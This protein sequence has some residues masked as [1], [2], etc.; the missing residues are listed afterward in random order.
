MNIFKRQSIC[1][2]RLFGQSNMDFEDRNFGLPFAVT[3]LKKSWLLADLFGDD[4]IEQ[5]LYKKTSEIAMNY[6]E[7]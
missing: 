5:K 4:S 3:F 7:T 1:I 2:Y 6:N